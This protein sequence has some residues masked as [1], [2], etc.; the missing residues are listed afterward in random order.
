MADLLF[1]SDED[2]KRD[3]PSTPAPR[4]NQ[5]ASTDIMEWLRENDPEDVY[6]LRD[7]RRALY[8]LSN[9]G[10]YRV[11]MHGLTRDGE[12][13]FTVRGRASPLLIVSDKSRHYLLRVLCRL[14]R[15][16]GWLPINQ[17]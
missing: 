6:D 5:T 8:S 10:I 16:R 1:L 9:H 15:R 12:Q 2:P 4:K 11:V 17:L 3:R 14:R 7:L 13:K